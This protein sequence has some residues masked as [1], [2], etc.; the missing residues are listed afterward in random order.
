M[1]KVFY[2]A[3]FKRD[4]QGLPKRIQSIAE[5]KLKLFIENL[6]HPSLRIKKME[7]LQNI[8]EGSVTKNYRFTFTLKDQVCV[9]RRI[10]T[11]D[12]LKKEK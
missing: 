3:A 6:Q 12:I 1:I 8:W 11:H 5:K 10:G 2:S 7:G 9:L 4:F